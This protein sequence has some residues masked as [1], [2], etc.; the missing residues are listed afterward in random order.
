MVFKHF[1]VQIGLRVALLTLVL[2]AWTILFA[3]PG[4][5]VYPAGLQVVPR[6][7]IGID[8]FNFVKRD[9]GLRVLTHIGK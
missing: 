8:T 6:I 5:P 7:V 9:D 4:Y 2:V 1:S 3:V